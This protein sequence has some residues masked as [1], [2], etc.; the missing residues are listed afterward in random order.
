MSLDARAEIQIGYTNLRVIKKQKT[1]ELAFGQYVKSDDSGRDHQ[2]TK[3]KQ[4]SSTRTELWDSLTLRVSLEKMNQKEV[5]KE[6]RGKKNMTFLN[7]N[8]KSKFKKK[9]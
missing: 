1:G 8:E 7:L 3:C 4:E 2:E 6:I 5:I 9:W